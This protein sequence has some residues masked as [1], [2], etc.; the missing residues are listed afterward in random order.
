MKALLAILLTCGLSFLSAQEAV[1]VTDTPP[2]ADSTPPEATPTETPAEA[3]PD[4]EDEAVIPT[5]YDISRYQSTWDKNPF[6]LKTV[7]VTQPTVNWAQDYALAG[8]FN[9]KGKIRISIRNKQTNEFK[10]I[11]SDGKP[12]AEFR[13][14]KANFNRNRTEASAVIAKGTEEA[15]VKYDDTSAP[16]TV[17]I[18]NTMRSATAPGSPG[19]PGNPGGMTGAGNP[20]NPGGVNRPG[21]PQLN[22][23]GS[24]MPNGRV[25]NAPGLPGGVSSMPGNQAT[26]M[27]MTS[28]NAITQPSIGQP[29][30]IPTAPGTTP[31]VISRRRQLIPA[32]VI[33]AQP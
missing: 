9:N 27:P 29:G 28:G 2:T 5:T 7:A 19:A 26:G 1:P 12:D 33:P 23:P 18:N 15:E 11:S 10:H 21:Q 14:V 30:V 32:P 6:N 31:P 13:L 16:Q 25:F 3:P 22:K 8:M 17:T 20:G 4:V 24:T